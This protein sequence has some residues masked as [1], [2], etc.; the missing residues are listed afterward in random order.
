M[1]DNDPLSFLPRPRGV[2]TASMIQASAMT[3]SYGVGCGALNPGPRAIATRE[4]RS[5]RRYARP[6]R[7]TRAMFPHGHAAL[8]TGGSASRPDRLDEAPAGPRRGDHREPGTLG[9]ARAAP[10][11]LVVS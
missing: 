8:A 6:G 1:R 4:R 3:V 11:C 7:S 2:R 9:L 5:H 10:P